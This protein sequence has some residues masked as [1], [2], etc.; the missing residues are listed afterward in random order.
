MNADGRIEVFMVDPNRE[1]QHRWQEQRN[2]SNWS[3]DWS[4]LGSPFLGDP[5]VVS[6]LVD[7]S[8][9]RLH[10]FVVNNNNRELEYRW[11]T[12]GDS[13]SWSN[14]D[15]LEG[16]WSPRRRASVVQNANGRIE[17][18]MVGTDGRF[19]H[20]WQT[21]PNDSGQWSGGWALL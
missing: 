10:V 1:L 5:A 20:R 7:I 3:E 18:F 14:W 6:S 19:Y 13:K 12:A 11:Q 2:S 17:V 15:S 8:E 16:H 4:S 21:T 9:T